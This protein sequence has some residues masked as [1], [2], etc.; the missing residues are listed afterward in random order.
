MLVRSSSIFQPVSARSIV[1][2]RVLS[3]LLIAAIDSPT[4]KLRL[5]VSTANPIGNL[6]LTLILIGTPPQP[7][8]RLHS[9]DTSEIFY[10]ELVPSSAF[11]KKIDWQIPVVRGK[12]G[13]VYVCCANLR[14]NVVEFKQER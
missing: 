12:I 9:T 5:I 13:Q 11:T 3:N 8:I 10:N 7:E 14:S 2:D 1:P 4:F 6:S